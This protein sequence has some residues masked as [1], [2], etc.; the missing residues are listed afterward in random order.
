[1][2]AVNWPAMVAQTTT[3]KLGEDHKGPT[4]AP[5]RPGGAAVVPASSRSRTVS[6]SARLALQ[7][8]LSPRIRDPA[9]RATRASVRPI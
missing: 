1:M 5:A 4:R 8:L 6:R 9:L 2:S 3:P 7:L